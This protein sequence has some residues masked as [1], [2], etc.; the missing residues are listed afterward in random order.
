M[1]L[2]FFLLTF[3]MF[4]A[5]NVFS[6][7]HV[8]G[9][10][11]SNGTYV[12]PHYRSSPDGNPYNNY[13][14]PGNVNP[15]TG[16]VATGNPDTYLYNYYNRNSHTTP[17]T[18][19]S[20][21]N[22]MS[23]ANNAAR[24]ASQKLNVRMSPES[25]STLIA[26]L[27]Y[28]ENVTIIHRYYAPWYYVTFTYYDLDLQYYR[29]TSGYIHSSYLSYPVESAQPSSYSGTSSYYQA[30]TSSYSNA[31]SSPAPSEPSGDLYFVITADLDVLSNPY[32]NAP[33]IT[34]LTYKD[35][36]RV[37]SKAHSPWYQ[38]QISYL[39][40][41]LHI[42]NTS[43]AYIYGPYLSQTAPASILPDQIPVTTT[44]QNISSQHYGPNSGKLNLW[45]NIPNE[46]IAVYVD[47]MYKGQLTVLFT[48][49][50]SSCGGT[51]MISSIE[52][53]GKHLVQAIGKK[54]HWS[55]Y[56]NI[57]ANQCQ[58]MGMGKELN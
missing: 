9:Y 25:S 46:D 48:D 15:Y 42:R 17:Q 22:G 40:E 37:L 52:T 49:Q 56:V 27:N 38:V 30:P 57:R 34:R 43:S 4:F 5:L 35:G 6:Q 55:G 24:V 7:V 44:S 8:N 19:Y 31:S 26:T 39:D 21:S 28:G 11:R 20:P 32:D 13:S 41:S 2:L 18:S 16:K 51:G 10:Y 50:P 23:S 54:F 47:H 29:T 12:Q 53:E 14:F 45:N 33:K 3:C 1:K 58:T 36:V